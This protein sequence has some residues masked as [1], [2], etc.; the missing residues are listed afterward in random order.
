MALTSAIKMDALQGMGGIGKSVIARALCD[1]PDV[2][3]AF[4]GGILWAALGQT[5]NLVERLRE[6]VERLGGT[7]RSTAPTADMLKAE[8]QEALEGRSC[9]LI[10]DDVWNKGDVGYFRPPGGLAA[11][12]DHARCGPGRGPGGGRAA[13]PG[14]GQ[15]GGAGPAGGGRSAAAHEQPAA[16][17]QAAVVKRLGYLPLAI[18][19]AGPQL[20]DTAAEQWLPEFDAYELELQR[21]QSEH[22]S[23]AWTFERSLRDAAGAEAAAV[24]RPGRLS[25]R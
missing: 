24:R 15:G 3:D 7:V 8:L 9:L 17:E 19:L 6:W 12:A 21:P 2:Q 16:A 23:L 14:D 18:M 13:D 10:L 11:A 4:P 20:R 1:D 25:R 22:D 5:P